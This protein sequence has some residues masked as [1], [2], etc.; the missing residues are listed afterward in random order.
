MRLMRA[1][2]SSAFR[3]HSPP[4]G[5][6]RPALQAQLEWIAAL[7]ASREAERLL[8]LADIAPEVRDPMLPALLT[9]LQWALEE[10]PGLDKSRALATWEKLMQLDLRGEPKAAVLALLQCEA[11]EREVP[12]ELL[13]NSVDEAAAGI[14][15]LA[16]SAW[17]NAA[18]PG[19]GHWATVGT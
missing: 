3:R 5:A 2:L 13:G 11:P 7:P 4:P 18:R 15:S 1:E 19:R 14:V 12:V 8:V 17:R 16:A 9:L 10:V 6:G